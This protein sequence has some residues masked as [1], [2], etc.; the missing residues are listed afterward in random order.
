VG[1]GVQ[2]VWVTYTGLVGSP[3]YGRW[4]SF[5]LTR[6]ANVASGIGTWTG[7]LPLNGADP[8]KVRFFVQ[9]VNGIGAAAA[10][11]N[12][13]RYFLLGTS[14]LD[15]IGTVGTP[16]SLVFVAPVPTSGFYRA[17]IALQARLTGAGPL[18]GKRIQFRIGSVTRSVLTDGNGAASTTLLVNALP[19]PQ[20]LEANFAGDATYQS[21]SARQPFTLLKMPTRLTFD[22]PPLVSDTS[23]IAVTLRAQDGTPLRERTVVF[24]L[25]SGSFRTSVA[26]ITN[27]FGQARLASGVA[28][29][30]T[31]LVSAYFAVPV[32][33]LDGS[34]VPLSDS[35]YE[36][37]TASTTIQV[38]PSF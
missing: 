35:L 19:G 13:G 16:T 38:T 30:R 8:T 32:V 2:E 9:A 18:A 1:A 17:D 25:E 23:G 11:T 27:G 12:F 6:P 31:Y 20:T 34:V 14:T 4:Q 28:G 29:A 15:G 33:F 5:T 21:S 22:S 24:L 7:I 36:G 26:E 10:N 3:F 37:S